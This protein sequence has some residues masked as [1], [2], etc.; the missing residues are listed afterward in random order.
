MALL[1]AEQHDPGNCELPDDTGWTRLLEVRWRD[2]GNRDVAVHWTV[3]AHAS[4]HHSVRDSSAPR[5]PVAATDAAT[6]LPASGRQHFLQHMGYSAQA[7]NAC[8]L[9]PITTAHNP[10]LYTPC[11]DNSQSVENL[12][13]TI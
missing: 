8:T 5:C 2:P 12:L 6:E 1:V 13:E 10:A 11:Y 7:A 9:T 3:A 4:L